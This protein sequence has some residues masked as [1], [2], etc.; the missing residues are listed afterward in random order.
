MP[1]S[2]FTPVVADVAAFLR[3]RTKT[4]GGAEAGTFNPEAAIEQNITRPTSEQ[5]LSLIEDSISDTQAAFGADIP[6][7]PGEDVDLFRSSVRRL[8]ALGAA[9][10]VELTYYPEQVATGRSPYAQLKTLYDDRMKRLLATIF[11]DKDGDGTP[12]LPERDPLAGVP[13]GGGYP[14]TAIGMEF[15]W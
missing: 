9:L 7:A 11:P 12:D 3:A 14:T 10:L 15:P 1:V 2:D 5:V 13:S 6:D 4:R 8:S